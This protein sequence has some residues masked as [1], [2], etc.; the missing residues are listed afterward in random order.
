MRFPDC[1]YLRLP[2]WSRFLRLVDVFDLLFL[3][4]PSFV[5]TL[6]A[7]RMRRAVVVAHGFQTCY[8]SS[9]ARLSS[10]PDG[11][12]W[13]LIFL[14][15]RQACTSRVVSSLSVSLPFIFFFLSILRAFFVLLFFNCFPAFTSARSPKPHFSCFLFRVC[16]SPSL[17]ALRHAFHFC[18]VSMTLAI[19]L[20][21]AT[22][23]LLAPSETSC[24]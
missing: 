7:V 16:V 24:Q 1:S 23:S 13:P 6:V 8:V 5:Y 2:L 22:I 20:F 19:S 15:R 21:C 9:C 12:L 17:S 3:C 18:T 4:F 11:S 14:L 10:F